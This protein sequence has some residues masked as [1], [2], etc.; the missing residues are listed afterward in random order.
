MTKTIYAAATM[1]ALLS[2]SAIAD[3]TLGG[4]F[5]WSYQDN[6]ST[7]S[8][9]VDADV[10]IKPSITTDTGLTISADLNINQDGGDDGGNSMTIK[11]DQFALDL[12]DVNSALDAIDDKT[13]WG[14][15]L[16]NGSPSVDHA[17]ILTLTPISGL[18]V[19]ASYASGDDYGTTAGEGYAVS[20]TYAIGEIATVGAGKMYNA[21][22]S[23]A[24][25]MNVSGSAG[26]IGLAAE[27]YTD[28]TA[29]GVDTDTTT[30]S[31]TYSIGST[32]VGVETMKAESAGTVSSD[33]L[34]WGIHQT[35][36]PGLVA[37]V[38][39]TSDDKTA[40]EKTTA[41]G[42]AMTF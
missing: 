15:V 21:D 26:P 36:A 38:E 18:K 23:E 39:M 1:V 29:A 17:A 5:E 37:F 27:L 28:T 10:N 20:V 31:A 34:T 42:L 7:I 14:Y 41:I 24:V 32:T 12:G 11:N 25:V 6:D 16:T 19:N 35:V 30:M 13:D 33:E 3:V 8:T 9:A 2:T 40:S 22:D 4:D